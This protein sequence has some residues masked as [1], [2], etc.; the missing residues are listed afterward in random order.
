MNTRTYPI[1][2][3]SPGRRIWKWIR[4]HSRQ[5]TRPTKKYAPRR[6]TV[7]VA[8]KLTERLEA[9]DDYGWIKLYG[10]ERGNPVALLSVDGAYEGESPMLRLRHQAPPM[11]GWTVETYLPPSDEPVKRFDC[12]M[13]IVD[14][15]TI[16]Y[17]YPKTG[18]LV[19]EIFFP[20]L[21]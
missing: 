6:R 19:W 4:S 5:L 11:P 15:R 12:Q 8:D 7:R 1:K 16:P 20:P 2:R 17:P 3:P 14:V 9:Y 18:L 13:D 21:P 10:D